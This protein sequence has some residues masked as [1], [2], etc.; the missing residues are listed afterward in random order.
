MTA[1]AGEPYARK[2]ASI[3]RGRHGGNP[4]TVGLAEQRVPIRVPRIR[5]VAGGEILLRP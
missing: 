5:S 2:D 4:G 1:L 3:G